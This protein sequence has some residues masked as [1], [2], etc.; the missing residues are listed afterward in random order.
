MQFQPASVRAPISLGG[1]EA[2]HKAVL[3]SLFAVPFASNGARLLAVLAW[4]YAMHRRQPA[5]AV[6]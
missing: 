5:V 2:R 6:V 3:A 4:L 1:N